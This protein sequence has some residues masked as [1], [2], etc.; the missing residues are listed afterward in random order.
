[1]VQSNFIFVLHFH[2][3]VGQVEWVLERVYKN[4]YRLIVEV[5]KK[6]TEARVAIHLSGPLLLYARSRWSEWL[7][8]LAQ[9]VRQGRVELLG[10]MYS[11]AVFPLVDPEDAM[12]QASKYVDLFEDTFGIRPRGFWI[13]ERA[14]EPHIPSILAKFDYEYTIVDDNLLP[15]L[16]PSSASR[17]V[18][19]TESGGDSIKV[20]F[21]DTQLRYILPWEA[22][23]RALDYIS[24]SCRGLEPCYVLWG[25]DAEKFGEWKDPE[26]AQSWLSSFFDEIAQRRDVKMVT[27]TEYLSNVKPRGI[28]YLVPGSYDKMM[29]WSQGNFRNFLVKYVESNHMHKRLIWAKKKLKAL[30]AP[31]E[32]WNHYLL[33]QCNDAYWHG[34]FGGIYITHLRQA[35]Y[36]NIIKAEMIAEE[37]A[38]YFSDKA[39]KVLRA[40]F[41]YDGKDEVIFEGEKLNIVVD[42]DNGGTITEI[43]FKFEDFV[44]NLQNTVTRV[45]EPYLQDFRG[46]WY[47]RVSARHHL[48]KT[49]TMIGDWM[50][51]TPFVDASNLALGE[52]TVDRVGSDGVELSFRGAYYEWG[53]EPVPVLTGKRISVEPRTPAIVIEH[54][55]QNVGDSEIRARLGFEYTLAPRLPTKFSDNFIKYIVD[56]KLAKSVEEEW[57]GITS[58]VRLRNS[59]GKIV[60]ISVDPPSEVWI[61]PLVMPART[62]RGLV[63]IFEGLG[64][65]VADQVVL[66]PGK[67]ITKRV[68]ISVQPGD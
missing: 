7:D 57:A 53:R 64:I 18:W 32:A 45:A 42:P 49:S 41:D 40:D 1:V 14:W 66:E 61:A 11:E 13:P 65:M 10:G 67:S 26:W 62:E 33:A 17:S 39:V 43:D 23:S 15:P 8:E 47:R 55:V 44:H 6:K 52:Y 29:Q 31:D 30:K 63:R 51:N 35:I 20:F 28:M 36:E 27:P 48:W 54:S 68:R 3:P 25:S 9:L 5:L 24:N 38:K 58:E 59:N 21:I 22:P 46:D 16:A 60:V 50:W 19:L 4:S 2:Q 12:A 34:L 56:R 37:R